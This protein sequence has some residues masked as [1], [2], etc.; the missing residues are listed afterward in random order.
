MRPPKPFL[1]EGGGP[2]LGVLVQALE[3]QL[4]NFFGAEE[5]G[6][7]VASVQPGS[8]AQKAGLVAGDV[9][10]KIND[11]VVNSPRD[12]T[13]SLAL[14]EEEELAITVIREKKERVV[15]VNLKNI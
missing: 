2:K 1:H 14:A 7:L 3:A 11:H 13:H 12:V 9:I 15:T 6:V 8:L 10:Y 5:G 4:A